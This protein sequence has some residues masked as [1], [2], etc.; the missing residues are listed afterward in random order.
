MKPDLFTLDKDPLIYFLLHSGVFVAGLGLLFFLLGLC[1]GWAVWSRHK[2]RV[3]LLMREDSELREEIADLKRKLAAA[4]LQQRP[5]IS[6]GTQGPE[7][8]ATVP[9][10]AWQAKAV[11]PSDSGS[12]AAPRVQK[13][14]S[15]APRSFPPAPVLPQA[16]QS[17]LAA[18]TASI[19][20]PVSPAPSSPAGAVSRSPQKVKLPA[21]QAPAQPKP[22]AAPQQE[23]L[24][25][26]P[27]QPAPAPP[28]TPAPTSPV[29]G[30]PA[31]ASFLLNEPAWEPA[32]ESPLLSGEELQ[33]IG[34]LVS[35]LSAQGPGTASPGS[36]VSKDTVAEV[37][38]FSF[39]LDDA[40]PAAFKAAPPVSTGPGP[41]MQGL[42]A[43]VGRVAR[44]PRLPAP[45]QPPSGTVNDLLLG[46]VFRQRPAEVDDLTR[47]QGITLAIQAHLA[48]LGIYTFRQIAGWT[49]RNLREIS[50]RLA[51]K[52]RIE[53]EQW[54]QQARH[55]LGL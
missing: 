45:V 41:N 54:V 6:S 50:L 35:S 17:G 13:P 53:R 1:M 40:A 37:E 21:P 49:P 52:D 55:L 8:P 16:A 22:P 19:P 18:T 39:L 31:A 34:P 5:A 44:A 3:R 43:A 32:P 14:A 33:K 36:T 10:P 26:D 38:P 42:A 25:A 51:F 7:K 2:R 12:E 4:T 48:E 11:L 24:P 30:T 20:S 23:A 47:I 29:Q 28:L 15:P 46:P 27:P 9:A